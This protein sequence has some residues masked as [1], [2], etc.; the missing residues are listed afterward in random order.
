[1]DDA[2]DI[3]L[4]GE[5]VRLFADRALY[6]PA[7]R[8]LLVADVH[9]GKDDAFR[10]AGIALPT[11]GAHQ[12]LDRLTAL[13]A[14]SGAESVWYL[15]DL[16]HGRHI[17]TQWT[18]AWQAFRARHA[19]MDMRL[20]EGNHDRAATH[21]ALGIQLQGERVQDGPFVFAHAPCTDLP[22]GARLAICGHVHPVVRVPGFR[23]RFPAFALV[24]QQLVLP[25]F[26]LFTGGQLVERAQARYGCLAGH[27]LDIGATAPTARRSP[28]RG[29]P[30][31]S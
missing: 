17:D 20:I 29:R 30:L 21:A 13:I 22:H 18:Q 7:R 31:H 14:R 4:A 28:R 27:L 19:G 3:V 24:E 9:L 23:G 16:L 15:G 6:W 8:R 26:S 2:L 11:G 10:A 5:P 1:M 25:A 12:D